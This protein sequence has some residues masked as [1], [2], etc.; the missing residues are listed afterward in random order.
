MD[1]NI[2]NNCFMI[3]YQVMLSLLHYGFLREVRDS[4]IGKK[5]GAYL[6]FL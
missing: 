4:S 6:Q 3:G 2:C 1:E 5:T